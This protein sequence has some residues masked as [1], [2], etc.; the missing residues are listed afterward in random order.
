[1]PMTKPKENQTITENEIL[2]ADFLVQLLRS[3]SQGKNIDLA[4]EK[5][6]R[7]LD[8]TNGNHELIEQTLKKT[9]VE[10]NRKAFRDDPETPRTRLSFIMENSFSIAAEKMSTDRNSSGRLRKK[11]SELTQ[12]IAYYMATHRQ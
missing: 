7:F 5:L 9:I 8:R 3:V 12:N 10:L 1:M 6:I 11:N 4:K 2:C